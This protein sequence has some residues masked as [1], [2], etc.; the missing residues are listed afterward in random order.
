MLISG[1][2][3]PCWALCVLAALAGA[4]A[5]GAWLALARGGAL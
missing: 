4:I 2:L 5:L 1:R 3:V